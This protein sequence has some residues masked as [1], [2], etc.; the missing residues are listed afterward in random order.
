MAIE[1]ELPFIEILQCTTLSSIYT[2]SLMTFIMIIAPSHMKKP[3][4]AEV[5]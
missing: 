4:L 3:R 2:I 5:K 1:A